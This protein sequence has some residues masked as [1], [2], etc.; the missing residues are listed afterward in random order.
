M[1]PRSGKDPKNARPAEAS[2]P[3]AASPSPA[4]PVDEPLLSADEQREVFLQV[5]VERA[6]VPRKFQNKTL[7]NFETRRGKDYK[8]IVQ[9]A[10]GYIDAFGRPGDVE[11]SPWAILYGATGSGKTHILAA[12]LRELLGRGHEAIFY[13][14]PNLFK[15]IRATFDGAEDLDEDEL[16]N[17]IVDV[18]ILALDDLGAEKTSDWVLDR[19]YLVINQRYESGRATLITTNHNFP[20]DL[21]KI[22]GSRIVSRLAEMCQII[23]PFP[24]QDYRMAKANLQRRVK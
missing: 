23:G 10:K 16:L 13:N 6:R 8:E 3:P 1:T 18:E 15:D 2:A 19:L 12:I 17:E 4:P 9:M 24:N 14:V 20:D 22:V 7:E 21:E 5:R 11:K